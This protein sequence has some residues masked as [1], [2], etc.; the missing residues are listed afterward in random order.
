MR[1][2]VVAAGGAVGV[3]ECTLRH[4]G[5]RVENTDGAVERECH[6]DP[7]VDGDKVVGI[8]SIRDVLTY[9]HAG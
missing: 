2:A 5:S 4:T 1:V 9:D 8:V 7:V 6:E 3:G